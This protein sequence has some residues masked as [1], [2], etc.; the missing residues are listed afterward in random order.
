MRLTV[1]MKD[2]RH[3]IRHRYAASCIIPEFHDYTGD[4]IPRFRWLDDNWFVLRED[5]GTTRTLHKDN[6]INGWT[7]PR[8][9]H[10][11]DKRYVCIPGKSR[12]HH[13]VS[14]SDDGLRFSCDC[15]GFS[16]RRTC[17]HIAEVMEAT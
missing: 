5:N 9:E 15:L 2:P 11:H 8:S 4:I 12:K 17:S 7:A 14:L 16:Y 13:T 10:V 6:I 1:R 3:D